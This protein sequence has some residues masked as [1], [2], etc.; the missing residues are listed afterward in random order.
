MQNQS[1]I[2][3]NAIL[4]TKLY[5]PVKYQ[6]VQRTCKRSTVSH[7]CLLDLS[8]CP[9]DNKFSSQTQD[10]CVCPALVPPTAFAED[11][12]HARLAGDM[13]YMDAEHHSGAGRANMRVNSFSEYH[14]IILR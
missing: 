14:R 8:R 4:K 13:E 9:S 6:R 2:T 11:V 7:Q 3:M 12:F 10:V 1:D 5:F